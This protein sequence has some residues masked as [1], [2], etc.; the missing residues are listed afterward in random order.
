MAEKKESCVNQA[1]GST[2]PVA[3]VCQFGFLLD[4]DRCSYSYTKLA[5][6]RCAI[7]SFTL[8]FI[9]YRYD[10]LIFKEVSNDVHL[11]HL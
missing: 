8:F 2:P 11:N 5:S 9:Q 10:E 7:L 4:D 1:M 3:K 6:K